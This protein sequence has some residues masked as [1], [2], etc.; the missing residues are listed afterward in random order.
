M[1]SQDFRALLD[2]LT[3]AAEAGD[4]AAF[5]ACFTS[6]GVY[7]DYVYGDHRGR[8]EIAHMITDLFHRDASDYRWEMFDPVCAGDLGY[9]WSLSTFLSTVPEFAG[10][11]V[12]IDGMSRF[13]L[14]DGL[15]SEYSE[16]VN[17]GVAMVQ[18]GVEPPRMQKVLRRWA[19]QLQERPA[20]VAFMARPRRTP[21]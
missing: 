10:R 3:A 16:S 17:G 6:D 14:K 7:R 21:G 11:R 1:T 4:G 19:T 20:T 18:L 5:A 2:R 15:I 8:A 12:V 9:A 13:E